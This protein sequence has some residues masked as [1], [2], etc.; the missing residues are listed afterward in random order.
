[1]FYWRLHF[2]N[3][4][5]EGVDGILCVLENTLGATFRYQIDGPTVTWQGSE[6]YDEEA[7]KYEVSTNIVEYLKQNA[8]PETR[9]YTSVELNED[10]NNYNIR[11][12][13]SKT[14]EDEYITDRPIIYAVCAGCIFLFT[15]IVFLI[16]DYLVERR[17][18]VVMDRAVKSTTLVSSL[19][20]EN[21]K[22]QLL[23]SDPIEQAPDTSSKENWLEGANE[24]E[25][26][27]DGQFSTTLGTST[28]P[29]RVGKPIAEAYNDTTVMFGDIAG[30]TRWSST[31]TPE[32]VFELLETLYAVFDDVATKR[33]VRKMLLWRQSMVKY[34]V[35]LMYTCI[36]HFV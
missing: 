23:Q 9:S 7:H 11:V 33:K 14:F 27:Q 16:Y 5:P 4:L 2:Q 22:E 34:N 20:P 30:F 6:E 3:I 17:Q 18:E 25:L 35:L 36:P 12:F 10:F 8:A 31:R 13:P 19:F 26:D 21:V 32:D 28:A 29:R 15:S 1:M 24:L